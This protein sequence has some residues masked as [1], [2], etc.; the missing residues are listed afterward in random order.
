MTNGEAVVYEEWDWAGNGAEST[1]PGE[2]GGWA[3]RHVRGAG[4]PRT[5]A[6]RTPA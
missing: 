2:A 6:G 1:K 4:E 5:G 3:E